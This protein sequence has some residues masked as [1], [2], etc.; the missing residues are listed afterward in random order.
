M[1][2]IKVTPRDN[3]Q[4]KV[5]KLGFDY[6]T[7]DPEKYGG[8]DSIYW[9]EDSIY[10][11]S[12]DEINTIEAA[13][14]ELYSRC[15]DAVDYITRSRDLMNRCQIP[16][17]YH[18]A[19]RRS[20]H[21]RD[22]DLYARFD[23]A[24]NPAI[25]PNPKMYEINADTPTS[26]FE[27]SIV[28]WFW[29][30]D[31]IKE[32]RIPRGSDQFNSMHERLI[33]AFKVIGKRYVHPNELFHFFSVSEHIEDEITVEYIRDTA[34]QA[35]LN[36]K[37]GYMEDIGWDGNRFVDY[38]NKPITTMFKLYP[39]EWMM[40]EEFGPHMSEEVMDIVEPIWKS[41]LSNK[42][43]LPILHEM[44]PKHPNI[45]PAADY[46]P[47][48]VNYV[49]KP[50]FSREGANITMVENGKQLIETSGDYGSEGFIYQEM[51]PLP[52]FNGKHPVIGS[53][54]I[55][56]KACGMGIREDDSLVTKNT[57]HFIPHFI[58]D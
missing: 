17:V 20:W 57:S 12:M 40:R 5:E 24:F 39:W 13:T 53:W 49:K 8:G 56:G 1:K 16:E 27:G 44:F 35:G 52:D 41:I 50:I 36:T 9:V 38:D 26:I 3:W 55:G 14:N 25:D 6:H 54:I 42:M 48:G 31:S 19:I 15:L 33:E 47:V 4:E 46:V 28:Q 21:R 32:G 29:L 43:L 51:F 2:R 23:L 34:N 45:L 11:F 10:Q 30:E 37:F 58:I 22:L 18:D 7:V